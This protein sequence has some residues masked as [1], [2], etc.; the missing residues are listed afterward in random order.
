MNYQQKRFDSMIENNKIVTIIGA[1]VGGLYTAL[2]FCKKGYKV[3]VLERSQVVGGLATSIPIDGYSID[4]GPHYMTLKKESDITEE[5]FDLVG[6]NNVILIEDI[7][8]SYLS[9]YDGKILN[10]FPTISDAIFSTGIKSIFLSMLSIIKQDRSA[11]HDNNASA[12]DYL[13]ACF[14]EYLFEQWCKPYLNQNFGTLELPLEYV[15]NRFK[16]ITLNKIISKLKN[17]K[18]GNKD[19]NIKKTSKEYINCY[20]KQ[21][22][23]SLVKNLEDKIQKNNGKIFL[24]ANV[25]SIDHENKNI[26][27][28]IKGKKFELKSDIIIYAT[29]PQIT[30]KWFKNLEINSKSDNLNSIMV[31]LFVDSRK[32]FNGWLVSIF[33][34]NIPFFRL[35]QQ[36]YLSS[37]V[38]PENKTL[39]TAEIRLEKENEMWNKSDKEIEEIV[40]KHLREMKILSNRKIDGHKVM[41]FPNLYP[42]F[43]PKPMNSTQL[44]KEIMNTKNEYILGIA[45]LDTG[46]FV[47]AESKIN[48]ENMPSIGGLYNAISNGKKLVESIT[49][50]D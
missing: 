32:L 39:L 19:F 30:A 31:F 6:K 4:I 44:E 24:N 47:T 48:D 11:L 40:E 28:E 43:R 36:N 9:Y 35:S 12:T 8:K 50:S 15:K 10:S 16:P 21:G 22:I 3:N 41:K 42:R 23:G 37:N 26:N 14:G 18:N 17:K 20:F 46:R 7:E 49:K 13:Q 38:S 25:T 2:R 27:Y 34:P 1:G 33:D 45:E 5:I 29:S